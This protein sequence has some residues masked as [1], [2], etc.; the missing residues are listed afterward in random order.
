MLR[1]RPVGRGRERP[2]LAG[3][4]LDQRREVLVGAAADRVVEHD[5]T[6]REDVHRRAV[7]LEAHPLDRRELGQRVDDLCQAQLQRARAGSRLVVRGQIDLRDPVRDRDVR[8]EA[9]RARDLRADPLSTLGAGRAGEQRAERCGRDAPRGRMR[10]KRLHESA[11]P[12]EEDLERPA[13]RE[14]LRDLRRLRRRG[15][16]RRRPERDRLVRARG[17]EEV[18]GGGGRD[19]CGY[20]REELR[21]APKSWTNTSSCWFVSPAMRFDAHEEKARYRSSALNPAAVLESLPTSPPAARLTSVVAPDAR[22]WTNSSPT[23]P[24]WSGASVVAYDENAT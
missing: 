7:D 13:G 20:E 17:R 24:V 8:E 21:H 3:E 22:S 2:P 15:L 23:P 9:R 11:V 5:S 14:R 6:A 10:A 4:G 12:H 1:Q 18:A 19:E 16:L